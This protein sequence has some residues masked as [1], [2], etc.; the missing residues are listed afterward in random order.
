MTISGISSLDPT[1]PQ[2]DLQGTAQTHK[3]HHGHHHHGAKRVDGTNPD[4]SAAPGVPDPND[5]ASLIGTT[6][7]VTA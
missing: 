2:D 1:A 5:P 4:A 3:H 7:R 6:L